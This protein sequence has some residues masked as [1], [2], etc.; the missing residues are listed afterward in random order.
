MGA[1]AAAVT[2]KATL[3]LVPAA[4]VTETFCDPRPALAAIVNVAVACVLLTTETFATVMPD[5]LR[6]TVRGAT[7]PAPVSVTGTEEP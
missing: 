2:L 7:K 1:P 3:A 5:P 6:L 4:V